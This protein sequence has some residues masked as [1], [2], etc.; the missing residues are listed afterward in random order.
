MYT[1]QKLW[2]QRHAPGLAEL[3]G[4]QHFILRRLHEAGVS[5]VPDLRRRLEDG[6]PLPLTRDEI[7]AL[8]RA[9]PQGSER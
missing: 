2:L 4:A 8:R 1:A 9:L 5:T 6:P 7:A 3:N